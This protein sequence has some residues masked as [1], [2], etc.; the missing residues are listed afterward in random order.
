MKFVC[1]LPIRDEADILP[2]T[3][4]HL[5]EWADAIFVFDTGSVDLSWDIVQEFA[6]TDHR[7]KP[8]TREPVY[9]SETRLRSWLFH[10]AR[11][12]LRN[13]DWFLRVDADEFHHQPPPDFVKT[14]LRK[15]ET[16]AYHQYYDFHLTASE[17]RA[18]ETGAETLADRRKPIAE[19]R[20]FYTAGLYTEPRLCRYRDTMQWPPTISFPFNAGYVARARLPVRHYPHRDPDQLRRR[21]RLRSIMMADPTNRAYWAGL[22][23]HH[24]EEADWRQFIVPDDLP[25]LR[26]WHPG[27]AL[28][29][30]HFEN[31]LAP[32]PI[33]MLQ[34]TAHAC[35]LPVLDR[36][37]PQRGPGDRPQPI[38]P[39]IAQRLELDLNL[40][41]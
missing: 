23:R 20:R 32:M 25:G 29:E 9:F 22:E 12:T 35:L 38:P 10:H 13:G 7:V 16:V 24:W 33:R 28:P 26:C 18:W 4:R 36:I 2:Q 17:V 3:L 8:V 40:T 27:Q 15:S 31:H 1:L 19:R 11:S 14:R 30:F 6:Q 5:L 34:R 39:H 37:R 21:C 41:M